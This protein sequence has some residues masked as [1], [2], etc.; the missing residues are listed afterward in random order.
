MTVRPVCTEDRI[1]VK[2]LNIDGFELTPA[3]NG[4]HI[5]FE[6]VH[7]TYPMNSLDLYRY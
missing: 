4:F 5:V 7:E 2:S 1:L 6:L 3:G